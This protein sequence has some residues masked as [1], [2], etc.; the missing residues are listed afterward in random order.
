MAD[1]FL[2]DDSLHGVLGLPGLAPATIDVLVLSVSSPWR[3]LP[4]EPGR[5]QG[6]T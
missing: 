3:N 2:A 6:N 4:S 5:T 1:D